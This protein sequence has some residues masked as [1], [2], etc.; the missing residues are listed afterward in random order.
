M[1]IGRVIR[2]EGRKE[3]EGRVCIYL[4]SHRILKCKCGHRNS[5]PPT[6]PFLSSSQ[7]GEGKTA[8][9]AIPMLGKG[10]SFLWVHT[11]VRNL[12]PCLSPPCAFSISGACIF[13]FLLN[14]SA[15]G[16]TDHHCLDYCKRPSLLQTHLPATQFTTQQV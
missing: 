5:S 9:A 15:Q 6:T 12:G 4:V 16:A 2:V 1:G 13:P 8:A 7:K 14:S 11:P 10:L 3:E